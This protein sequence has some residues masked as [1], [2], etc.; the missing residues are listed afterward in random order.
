MDITL[1]IAW[2]LQPGDGPQGGMK[3]AFYSDDRLVTTTSNYL[4]ALLSN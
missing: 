2:I 4:H 1:D 3:I